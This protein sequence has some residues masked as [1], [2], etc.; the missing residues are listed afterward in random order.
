MKRNKVHNK[1]QL[2]FFPSTSYTTDPKSIKG[3]ISK[4][5]EAKINPDQRR[6]N[7]MPKF[8]PYH[9][10]QPPLVGLCE[11]SFLDYIN[12]VI[13]K[14]HLC[15]LV[16]EVVSTLDTASIECKY[17]HLGQNSYHPK[18]MLNLLFYGYA[19]GTRGSRKLEEK[20]QSDHNYIFL[21]QCYTPDH[22]TISD[23]RKNN[24]EELE[25]YF[26]EMV[27]IFNTLGF[28]QVGKIYIDGTKVK[29][30][31]SAKRTKDK[32]G[33]E[34]WLQTI[35][36]EISKLMKEAAS[37]DAEEDERCKGREA[38]EELKKKLSNKNY[39]KE[40]I[41]EAL[42][43]MEEENISKLNLTDQE[44][45]HMKAG[46]SKDIRPGYNCQASVSE[47]G[48]I[49]AAETTTDPN[50]CNQL[51]PIIEKSKSNTQEPVEEVTADSGYGNY[52]NYEYLEEQ[53]IEGY[54][55]D[56]YFHQYKS[57]EY[58]KESQRYH[59]TNFKYDKSI[60]SY[61]CPEGKRLK[62]WKT[63]LN[64]SSTRQW[65]HKVYK[66]TECGNC[67]KRSLCTKSKP[68]FLKT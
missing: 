40:K 64:K 26:V 33:F 14:E 4:Q 67:T 65:N 28:T 38:D 62:Y 46:G 6:I 3:S 50:D 23:F 59:Y 58:E 9:E 63:R 43:Q 32:K 57:G 13:P 60:E 34:K 36:E 29:G 55:P 66:G 22:R 17:S 35:E 27:R 16:K 11:E 47:E 52:A 7:H 2:E 45:N 49:V 39:L 15:R 8:K 68:K 5:S 30:N 54:V 31:A 41:K 25:K 20:C 44:A 53:K 61:I 42:K 1:N 10:F 19:T 18:L 12:T 24:L 56:R 37:I 21:M 51:E 48:V